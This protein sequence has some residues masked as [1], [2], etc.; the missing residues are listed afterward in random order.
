MRPPQLLSVI[1]DEVLKQELSYLLSG[2]DNPPL[3]VHGDARD[4][5]GVIRETERDRPE[6]LLVEVAA[7]PTEMTGAFKA[8]R[9][10]Y[11]QTKI[12]AVHQSEDPS[13]ILSALRAGAN[14]F[15]AP[16]F[17]KTLP[18]ALDRVV[19]LNE[20]E[21]AP[22]RQGKVVGFLSAKGGCGSTTLA[23]HI[24]ADLRRKTN[25]QVLLADLDLTSGM[26]GFLMKVNSVYSVL[27]AVANLSRLDESLW[28][29]LKTEWKPGVDVIAA[30]G[31]LLLRPR[32]KP[33]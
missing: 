5:K 29:A 22:T 10:A 30:P 19:R 6:V 25:K 32:S 31:R 20:E 3:L 12:I 18:P 23:C 1:R 4:W 16:P 15:V 28:K 11:S 9:K 24:A 26:V 17:E 7:L 13:I 2:L 33:R 8:V 27:D 21:H 14:E